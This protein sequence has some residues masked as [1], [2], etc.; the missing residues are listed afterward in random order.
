MMM[1]LN[2]I[3]SF[4]RARFESSGYVPGVWIVLL[5]IHSPSKVFTIFDI[6]YITKKIP[7]FPGSLPVL[8]IDSRQQLVDT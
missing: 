2:D 5:M 3:I 7:R 6:F 4:H 8:K 1:M